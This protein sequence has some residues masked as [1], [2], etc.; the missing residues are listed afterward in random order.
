MDLSPSP[1]AICCLAAQEFSNVLW[2]WNMQCRHKSLSWTRSIQSIPSHPVSRRSV[3]I[4]SFHLC[5]KCFWW[6]LSF[7]FSHQNP[8][9]IPLHPS[10][11]YYMFCSSYPCWFDRYKNI[12]RGVQ[13]MKLIIEFSA[14]SCYFI[15]LRSKYSPQHTYQIPSVCVFRLIWE[16]K[17]HIHTKLQAQL[18]FI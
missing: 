4:L 8:A 6:S 13:I 15:P 7:W 12:C 2:N 11:S 9:W 16:T 1:K 18:L 14:A 3:L 10:N 17:I 5:L